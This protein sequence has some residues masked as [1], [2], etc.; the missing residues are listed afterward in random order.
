MWPGVFDETH[1]G[2]LGLVYSISVVKQLAA[3]TAS[4]KSYGWNVCSKI[5]MY[6]SLHRI[7]SSDFLFLY[8]LF[9]IK[10]AF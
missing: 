5:D 9:R 3:T 7:F 6:T 10:E 2:L 4:L 1:V 8:Y